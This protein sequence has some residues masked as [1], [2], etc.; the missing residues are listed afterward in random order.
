MIG[1]NTLYYFKRY[2]Y[3]HAHA[4]TLTDIFI[5]CTINTLDY[6]FDCTIASNKP[7]AIKS[8]Y[9]KETIIYIYIEANKEKTP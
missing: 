2:S 5:S 8:E 4:Q 7:N 6:T 3:T 9:I 1:R